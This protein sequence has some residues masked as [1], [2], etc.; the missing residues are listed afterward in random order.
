MATKRFFGF[1][2]PQITN[3]EVEGDVKVLALPERVSLS[4]SRSG[5][6]PFTP[7]VKV[8]DAVITGQPLATTRSKTVIHSPVTGK[9]LGLN[10]IFSPDGQETSGVQILC[11]DIEEENTY[12]CLEDARR[13]SS[14]DLIDK[15]TVMGFASPWKSDDVQALMGEEEKKPIKA[16]LVMAVDREPGLAVQR[17]FLTEE[18]KSLISALDV[19]NRIGSSCSVQI[20]VPEDAADAAQA[21]FPGIKILSVTKNYPDNHWS[22]I[23][24]NIAGVGNIGKASAREAGFLVITAEELVAI[25]KSMVSGKIQTSKL[26]TVS[27]K[28]L[29]SPVTVATRIGSPISFVLDRAGVTVE[30]DDRV[31][32]G[33]SW[34]GYAQFDLDAPITPRT[35]GLTVIAAENVARSTENTCI[36]CGRCTQFCPVKIQVNLTARYA[37]FNLVEEAYLRGANACIECGICAYVCP[38]HRPLVQYMRYAVKSYEESQVELTEAEEVGV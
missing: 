38:A 8:G 17:R 30:K 25:E 16:V 37:E 18:R 9:I 29:P 36:N 26:V 31:I 1:M 7:L 3:S 20:A 6:L 22:R 5:Q 11:D 13:A 4:L 24:A 2:K 23:L 21:D 27:G 12:E 33:G 28:G 10:P 35:D 19:L 32:M 15:L 14:G 34:Q